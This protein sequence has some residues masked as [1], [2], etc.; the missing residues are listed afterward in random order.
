VFGKV[1]DSSRLLLYAFIKKAPLHKQKFD[2]HD[3]SLSTN[4]KQNNLGCI[5]SQKVGGKQLFSR[6]IWF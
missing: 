1:V 5:K 3:I 4:D 6:N 2:E